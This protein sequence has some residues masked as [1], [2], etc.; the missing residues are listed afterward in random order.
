M[1]T[2]NRSTGYI[3]GKERA[4]ASSKYPEDSFPLLCLFGCSSPTYFYHRLHS[5]HWSSTWGY[6]RVVTPLCTS[7]TAL[8]RPDSMLP[9][10][11][12]HRICS[13][14]A[15]P[16][17]RVRHRNLRR[18]VVVDGHKVNHLKTDIDVEAEKRNR[19]ANAKGW[20]TKGMSDQAKSQRPRRLLREL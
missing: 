20:Q 6:I 4:A 18:K 9:L 13:S 16:S 17:Q 11:L 14:E 3:H 10:R 19:N 15:T 12:A 7:H 5:L 2:L 8:T 1:S